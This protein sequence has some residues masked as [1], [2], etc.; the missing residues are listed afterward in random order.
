MSGIFTFFVSTRFVRRMFNT[1]PHFAHEKMQIY[2]LTEHL[3]VKLF[4][5]AIRANASE[6]RAKLCVGAKI[7]KRKQGGKNGN[8]T[9]AYTKH[10]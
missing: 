6:S 9:A 10:I 2:S 4:K 5:N 3:D 8:G 7:I 1:P